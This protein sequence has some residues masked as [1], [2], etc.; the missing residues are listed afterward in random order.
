VLDA[1]VPVH[2]AAARARR[3]S[4]DDRDEE[5]AVAVTSEVATPT[6]A[7]ARRQAIMRRLHTTGFASI[8]DLSQLFGVSDMTIRRDL[9][10]LSETGE[11]RVVHGGASLPH[12]T[13]RTA[14][15]ASRAG[16]QAESKR[17]IAEQAATLIEHNA[18]VAVDAGT[19][20]YELATHLPP[21][22]QGTVI[23]HSIPVLQH[24]L[25][26]PDVQV[27]ALG[28]QLLADSQALA[29]EITIRCLEGLHA[30]IFFLAAAAINAGGIYVTADVERPTKR[31]L[32]DICDRVVVLADHTKFTTSAPIRLVTF[33]LV[34][35]VV[36]DQP[37]PPAVA[38]ALRA[39]DVELVVC[40]G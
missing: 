5:G 24:L 19:T 6:S 33:D 21:G 11:L 2:V 37:P 31:A 34:D 15:F 1:P 35:V 22:F 13:L 26:L 10:R 7:A 20:A 40:D 3:N 32:I 23:T 9:K 30:E 28:G 29:G 38:D 36:T 18:T 17:R 25:G 12:G 27:V 8:T 39:A 4:G 16:Q 14:S